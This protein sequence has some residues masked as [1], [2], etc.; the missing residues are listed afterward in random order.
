MYQRELRNPCNTFKKRR[1]ARQAAMKTFVY[2]LI[3]LIF[4]GAA[5]CVAQQDGLRDITVQEAFENIDDSTIIWMDIRESEE[6]GSLP[7]LTFA[8]HIPMSTFRESFP[9]SGI[10]KDQTVYIIC[11]S[12]N[13]SKRV[14]KHLVSQGYTGTVNVLGGMKAW[15]KM[16]RN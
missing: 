10:Q 6:F 3:L 4:F 14:Q 15:K 13:R 7:K 9:A 16:K 8:K 12:G 1:K 5:S 2:G 11:R